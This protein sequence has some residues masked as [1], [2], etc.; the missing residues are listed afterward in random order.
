[1][2]IRFR[3]LLPVL[4]VLLSAFLNGYC[5]LRLGHW[6]GCE[7]AYYSLMPAIFLIPES[8]PFGIVWAFAAAL[9]QYV[10]LGSLLDKI[11]ASNR[12]T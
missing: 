11:L 8:L 7:F 12:E 6:R 10:L 2:K 5:L 4:Y 3:V 9:A 1:V